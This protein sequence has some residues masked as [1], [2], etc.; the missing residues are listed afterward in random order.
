MP[1]FKGETA[2]GPRR[3]F[4][5]FSDNA[6]LM[7]VR[8][9]DWKISFKSIQG[10]LFTGKED[11]TNVPL[12]TNLRQDPWE[13]FQSEGIMYGPLVGRSPLHVGALRGHCGPVPRDVQRISA[14]PGI[15]L[16]QRDSLPRSHREGR[17]GWWKIAE[18]TWRKAES[19]HT[20]PHQSQP[21]AAQLTAERTQ[22]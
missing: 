14:Q 16:E 1:F 20:G 12:L 3:E 11:S 8:Y 10:N 13:R 15:R 19:T 7:A 5:Y 22:Q 9:N 17:R 4:F 21:G 2:E 18:C 6:D